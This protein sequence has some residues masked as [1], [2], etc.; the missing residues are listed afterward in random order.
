VEYESNNYQYLTGFGNLDEE[1]YMNVPPGLDINN[2]KKLILRK[3]IYGIVQ[4]AREFHKKL[5]EDLN[6][7]GF[8]G[9]RSDL[10]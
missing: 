9:S 5:I 6:V 10:F 8:I 1:I 4:S 3:R 7:I 2:N